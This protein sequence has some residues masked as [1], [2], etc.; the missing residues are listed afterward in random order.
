MGFTVENHP[1]DWD[2]Y[3]RGAGPKRNDKMAK[4]GAQKC[5]AFWDGISSGTKDMTDRAQLNNIPVEVVPWTRRRRRKR[6]S[7]SSKSEG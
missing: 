6:V 2:R 5:I 7:T 1:A 4:L 3:G